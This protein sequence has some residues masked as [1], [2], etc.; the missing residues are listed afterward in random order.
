M[1]Y[2]PRATLPEYFRKFF[3]RSVL[4]FSQVFFSLGGLQMVKNLMGS[5][6]IWLA[7]AYVGRPLARHVDA[8]LNT[9]FKTVAK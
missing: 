5:P 3:W 7:I 2:R 9:K 8:L 1:D 6:K 4:F